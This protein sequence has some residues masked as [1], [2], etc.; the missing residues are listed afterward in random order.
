MKI[1]HVTSVANPDGNGVAV[2]VKNYF[3]YE[4]T[5]ADVAVYNLES[6]FLKSKFSYNTTKYQNISSLPNGFNKPD[7]V[8]FNEVY[9]KEY[10][11]LYKECEKKGIAYIIIPHGCLTREAQKKSWLKKKIANPLFFN[12]FL[13]GALAIQYL[14][15]EE[16]EK[17]I[18]KDKKYI[19]AGNGISP[20]SK[21]NLCKNKEL[22]RKSVV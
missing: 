22:D 16:I 21:K 10:I 8:V 7:L 15:S 18:I 3:D 13:S 5:S 6:N 11:R 12:G 4:K 1:L 2:A 9:K 19:I 17:S 20:R 14:N